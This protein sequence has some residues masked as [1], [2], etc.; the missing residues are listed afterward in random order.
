MAGFYGVNKDVKECMETALLDSSSLD[1]DGIL[2]CFDSPTPLDGLETEY[3]QAQFYK[4]H[5]HYIV[6]P[7]FLEKCPLNDIF[8]QEPTERVL[9]RHMCERNGRSIEV[10]ECCYDVSLIDSLQRLLCMDAVREQ[11]AT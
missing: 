4:E 9:G 1:I 11:V 8:M 3:R 5:F 7:F 10:T 2:K 6:N